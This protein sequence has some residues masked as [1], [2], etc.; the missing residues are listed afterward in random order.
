MLRHLA[1]SLARTTA[2][3]KLI[4]L[5]LL[6]PLK[7]KGYSVGSEEMMGMSSISSTGS[8][9][10]TTGKMPLRL[11]SYRS[12]FIGVECCRA[13]VSDTMSFCPKTPGGV[14]NPIRSKT[15]TRSDR[16]ISDSI[17]YCNTSTIERM[18]FSQPFSF[19]ISLKGVMERCF[20]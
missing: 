12:L 2:S 19:F 8:L 6:G 16:K 3:P 1:S 13:L 9:S 18:L 10:S 5:I 20:C 17:L 7:S 11:L 15:I 14:R 4:S